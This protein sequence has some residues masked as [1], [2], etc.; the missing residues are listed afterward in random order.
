MP[1]TKSTSTTK[2]SA[3]KTPRKTTIASASK[4][5]TSLARSSPARARASSSSSSS[6]RLPNIDEKDRPRR[7]LAW[8]DNEDVRHRLKT[9]SSY[10]KGK[11]AFRSVAMRVMRARIREGSKQKLIFIREI[12][13]KSQELKLKP[14]ERQ[15]H[16]WKIVI[17][18]DS[19]TKVKV[20]CLNRPFCVPCKDKVY[21]F[22]ELSISPAKNNSVNKSNSKTAATTK[23]SPKPTS[24]TAAPKTKSPKSTSKSASKK[25]VNKSV[26]KSPLSNR[27]TS[28]STATRPTIILPASTGK[29]RKKRKSQLENLQ[30]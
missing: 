6:T 8:I 13:R 17:P 1:R 9:F 21:K 15:I 27:S 2:G 24:K 19:K 5:K 3:S 7:I 28:T 4:S 16:V 14:Q 18:E 10:A 23:K 29:P 20:V 30:S 12:N 11:A 22:Q 26:S 25:S